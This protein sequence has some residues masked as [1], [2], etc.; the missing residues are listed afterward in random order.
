MSPIEIPVPEVGGWYRALAGRLFEVVAVDEADGSIE[1]QHFDGTVEELDPQE[2]Q[3]IVP[4]DTDPPE[5]W[6]GAMDL[7]S[8]D[9][10]GEFDADTEAGSGDPLRGPRELD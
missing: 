7:S 1:I 5:D 8:E 10:L 3:A 6:S 9:F 2:W 4:R